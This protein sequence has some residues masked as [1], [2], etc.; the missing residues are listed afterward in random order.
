MRVLAEGHVYEVQN[1]D[2]DGSQTIHFVRRIPKGQAFQHEGILMQE[3][4][5]VLIDR[6]NFLNAQVP[7]HENVTILNNLRESLILLESRAA[8]RKLERATYPERIEFCEFCGHVFCDCP[9]NEL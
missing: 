1:I 8:R 5:R 3:L 7:C 9:E 6:T 2:G 4:I